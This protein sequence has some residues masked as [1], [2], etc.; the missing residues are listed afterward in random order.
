MYYIL[1]VHSICYH[2][3]FCV[4]FGNNINNLILVF[5]VYCLEKTFKI[6]SIELVLKTYFLN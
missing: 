6:S 1:L 3:L 5:L 4:F 2:Y